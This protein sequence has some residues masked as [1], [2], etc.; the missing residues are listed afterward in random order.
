MKRIKIEDKDLK[1]LMS[2]LDF[3]CN[4]TTKHCLVF[5]NSLHTIRV[6]KTT[7]DKARR[8]LNIK[9]ELKR[10]NYAV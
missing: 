2:K 6:S 4:V 3:V 1:K 7:S 9:S 8:L 5:T 10:L